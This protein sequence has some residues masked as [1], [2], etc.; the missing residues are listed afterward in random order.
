M[1]SKY[2]NFRITIEN[3]LKNGTIEFYNY[4]I[5]VMQRGGQNFTF[6]IK[7]ES[8]IHHP[9][10]T[11]DG[12]DSRWKVSY[13]KKVDKIHILIQKIAK[14]I[15][16]LNNTQSAM[17][18]IKI[19]HTPQ[20]KKTISGKNITMLAKKAGTQ[21]QSMIVLKKKKSTGMINNYDL[22]KLKKKSIEVK[23][24][25]IINKI[26]IL[27]NDKKN[28]AVRE[29]ILKDNRDKFKSIVS[30]QIREFEDKKKELNL[31][32]HKV[33]ILKEKNMKIIKDEKVKL[34]ELNND[35]KNKLN[36]Q[37]KE[38][39]KLKIEN[40]KYQTEIEDLHK[41]MEILV[42]KN[43]KFMTDSKSDINEKL[44]EIKLK[45]ENLHIKQLELEKKEE[46]LKIKKIKID[47][48]IPIP[49][50]NDDLINEFK[51]LCENTKKEFDI[52]IKNFL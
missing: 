27:K 35:Y 11:I 26:E 6:H 50:L 5:S 44:K 15:M 34:I 33:N 43:D 2:S 20:I 8:S 25:L 9:Y 1:A 7:I 28:I 3:R 12:A 32:I 38:F 48:T 39:E 36:I 10:G 4:Y 29:Q 18:K 31:S 45:S 47:C 17:C 22:M 30:I 51:E 37:I 16:E 40:E 46:D 21:I 41:K 13:N 23:D 49:D 19:Y 52:Q 24:D 14:K 42:E